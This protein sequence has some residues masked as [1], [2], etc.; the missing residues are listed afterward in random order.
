MT[1]RTCLRFRLD[2]LIVVTSLTVVFGILVGVCIVGELVY[3]SLG[4][5]AGNTVL[6]VNSVLMIDN[7]LLVEFL[8]MTTGAFGGHLL[9]AGS[10][11]TGG[12]ILVFGFHMGFV[13]EDDLAALVFKQDSN[14]GAF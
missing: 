6:F 2:G 8:D 4:M 5:V 14:R 13:G 1:V 9:V 7:E 12:A 11:V 3:H 10:M